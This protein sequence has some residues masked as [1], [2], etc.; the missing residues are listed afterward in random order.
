MSTSRVLSVSSAVLV[1][2]RADLS[3]RLR[4]TARGLALACVLLL[5]VSPAQADVADR[6]RIETV[7]V[8]DMTLQTSARDAFNLLKRRGFSTG[9]LETYEDWWQGGLSAVKGDYS[10]PDGHVEIVLARNGEQLVEIREHWIRL[11]AAFDVVAETEAVR[12]YFGLPVDAKDCKVAANQ[13]NA[14]CGV[15][16]ADQDLVYL[17]TFNGDRQRYTVVKRNDIMAA[18]GTPPAE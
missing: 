4:V 5:G 11:K 16:D 1:A 8:A 18:E 14:N 9:N 17:L 3:R 12:S 10:A 2:I 7:T 15:E 6:T 13:K